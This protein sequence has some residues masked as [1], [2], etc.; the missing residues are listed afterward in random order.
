[1]ATVTQ[2]GLG[3]YGYRISQLVRATKAECRKHAAYLR[4]TPVGWLHILLEHGCPYW[5]GKAT[6]LAQ[7]KTIFRWGKNH[8]GKKPNAKRT[9]TEAANTLTVEQKEKVERYCEKLNLDQELDLIITVVR[10]NAGDIICDGNHRAIA[11][12][13]VGMKSIPVHYLDIRY[14]EQD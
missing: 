13:L 4:P 9:V 1:M 10:T 11:C 6:G 2:K 14:P 5:I 12:H 8:L 3:K 7:M